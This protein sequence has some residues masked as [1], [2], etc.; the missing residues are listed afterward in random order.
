[1]L[2]HLLLERFGRRRSLQISAQ[3]RFVVAK[4]I[5][6]I[7]IIQQAQYIRMRDVLDNRHNQVV[8]VVNTIGG[9]AGAATRF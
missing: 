3:W 6:L 8:S 2:D 9:A 5:V 7:A 4:V 1:M